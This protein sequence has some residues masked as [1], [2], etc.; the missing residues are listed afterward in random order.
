MILR[1]FVMEK[2]RPRLALVVKKKKCVETDRG[3]Y[4]SFD[5]DPGY[6]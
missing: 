4:S 1:K 2:Y 5:S 3:N 6:F